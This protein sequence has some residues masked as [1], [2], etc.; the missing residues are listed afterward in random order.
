MNLRRV[1]IQ[2]TIVYGVLS[3]LAVGS[4]ALIAVRVGTTRINDSAERAGLGV[5]TDALQNREVSNTWI[6]DVENQ[7]SNPYGDTWVEPPLFGIAQQA[8]HHIL[9][10]R[11]SLN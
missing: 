2:L 1:R 6:V 11:L 5:I 9:H 7:W 10:I 3:I 8:L 4:I